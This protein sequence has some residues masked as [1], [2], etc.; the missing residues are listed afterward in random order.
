MENRPAEVL[1]FSLDNYAVS[2]AVLTVKDL[3]VPVQYRDGRI[4]RATQAFPRD[5]VNK[6]RPEPFDAG[7]WL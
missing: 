6:M 2:M 1:D 5:T 4:G 7:S 3:L